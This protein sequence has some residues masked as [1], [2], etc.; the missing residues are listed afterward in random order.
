VQNRSIRDL[1]ESGACG[2]WLV[3]RSSGMGSTTIPWCGSY[4][5]MAVQ[6]CA[7][8]V[9]WWRR[10]PDGDICHFQNLVPHCGFNHGLMG[11]KR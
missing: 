11:E 3:D 8:G 4:N 6:G 7:S 1:W 2:D 10:Q 9:D 5:V